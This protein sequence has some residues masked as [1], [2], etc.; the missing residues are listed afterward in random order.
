MDGTTKP[1]LALAFV[2]LVLLGLFL[3]Q[4]DFAKTHSLL[5]ANTGTVSDVGLRFTLRR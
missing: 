4:P 5:A 3:V 2:F 1:M